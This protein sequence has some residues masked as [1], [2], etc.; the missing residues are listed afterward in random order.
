MFGVGRIMCY[1]MFGANSGVC[2]GFDNWLGY[3]VLIKGALA[4]GFSFQWC[5]LSVSVL[6]VG[7]SMLALE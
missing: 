2:L 1:T 6:T 4:L 3:D 5:H 7:F